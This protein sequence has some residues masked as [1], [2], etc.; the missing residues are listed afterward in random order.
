[1]KGLSQPSP[2]CACK[3]QNISQIFGNQFK[4]ID[5]KI[6]GHLGAL[7]FGDNLHYITRYIIDKLPIFRGVT[8]CNEV[9]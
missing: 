7:H 6:D 9:M 8:G 5:K 2:F 4:K 1:M 3:I